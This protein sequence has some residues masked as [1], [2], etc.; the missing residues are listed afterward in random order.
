MGIFLKK[1]PRG[2]DGLAVAS[3]AQAHAQACAEVHGEAGITDWADVAI[4][5]QIFSLS[6]DI[7]PRQQFVTCTQIQLGKAVIP[8]PICQHQRITLL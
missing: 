6:V 2:V 7:Q 1:W 4:A 8:V 5:G 3:F